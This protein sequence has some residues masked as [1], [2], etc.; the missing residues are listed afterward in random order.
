LGIF[1]QAKGYLLCNRDKSGD[2]II[3]KA[4]CKGVALHTAKDFIIKGVANFRKPIR[5]KESLVRSHAAANLGKDEK[6]YNEVGANVWNEVKKTMQSVYIKRVGGQGR[7]RAV[8][9]A[10]ISALENNA[11]TGI[12]SISSDV[13]AMK[14]VIKDKKQYINHFA[15]IVIPPDWF[16]SEGPAPETV[17]KNRKVMFLSVQDLIGM[18]P[19][20]VWFAGEILKNEKN[21]F[22]LRLTEFKGQI[23]AVENMRAKIDE[24]FLMPFL[25]VKKLIVKKHLEISLAETYIINGPLMLTV[26]IKDGKNE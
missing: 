10:E 3:N 11:G 25:D 23:L 15:D 2:Y 24:N 19:E 9:V 1:R 4:A 22:F 13:D 21:Y 5:L 17:K 7:T 12:M 26:Q 14:L 8:Q 16:K 20:T 18:E 6:F